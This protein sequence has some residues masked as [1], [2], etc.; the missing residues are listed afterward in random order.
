MPHKFLKTRSRERPGFI[1]AAWVCLAVLWLMPCLTLGQ[2]DP[3][4]PETATITSLG[5]GPP[6]TDVAPAGDAA[7]TIFTAIDDARKRSIVL[8]LIETLGIS[9][10]NRLEEGIESLILTDYEDYIVDSTTLTEDPIPLSSEVIVSVRVTLDSH[11]LLTYVGNIA[12]LAPPP[13]DAGGLSEDEMKSHAAL[14]E[15]MLLQADVATDVLL[16][17]IK[18]IESYTDAMALFKTA[19]DDRGVY[20]CLM[21]IGR[22]YVSLGG[23]SEAVESFDRAEEIARS[24]GDLRSEEAARLERARLLLLTGDYVGAS[25]EVSALLDDIRG[26]GYDDIEARALETAALSD[27]AAGNIERALDEAVQAIFLYEG[28]GD[29]KSHY[30]AYVS[31]GLML[32][33]IGEVEAAIETLKLA[34]IMSER[35]EDSERRAR[36]LTALGSAF[37]V[38][39]DYEGARL[40]LDEAVT[41]ARDAGWAYGEARALIERAKL[42]IETGNITRAAGDA[43]SAEELA[44]TLDV[45]VLLAVS[46]YVQGDILI[47]Q[48]DRVGALDSY[49]DAL[50]EARDIRAAGVREPYAPFTIDDMRTCAEALVSLA[51]EMND[52]K[53]A[54]EAISYYHGALTARHLF[55][56]TPGDFSLPVPDSVSVA[57]WKAVVGRTLGVDAV[58][59]SPATNILTERSLDALKEQRERALG[60]YEETASNIKR[61][62]PTLALLAGIDRPDYSSL[63]QLLGVGCAHVQYFIGPSRSFALIVTVNDLEIV[64]LPTGSAAVIEATEDF[65]AVMEGGA[66][67]APVMTPDETI[68]NTAAV[69]GA[70]PDSDGEEVPVEMPDVLT[71]DEAARRAAALLVSPLTPYLAGAETI[72]INT[73]PDL[74]GLSPA[75]L[76]G[77]SGLLPES[78]V[79]FYCPAIFRRYFAPDPALPTLTYLTILGR[80]LIELRAN[81]DLFYDAY[82]MDSLEGGLMMLPDETRSDGDFVLVLNEV[83]E[84]PAVTHPAA[85]TLFSDPPGNEPESMFCFLEL[86]FA[87]GPERGVI[88]LPGADPNAAGDFFQEM[89]LRVRE[90]G[91]PK[92]FEHALGSADGHGGAGSAQY[93]IF[94][95]Y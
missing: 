65:L 31:Y 55:T 62:T 21:G 26:A 82:F 8:F 89:I 76:T 88:I 11:A 37:F 4:V 16:D 92:G 36:V 19:R 57:E 28:L 50:A 71:A 91:A 46:L 35:M 10:Y 64:T 6:Q 43:A 20:T 42:S 87:A 14:A 13:E 27:F 66:A 68:D 81:E 51:A 85:L 95:D 38:T 63:R 32:L 17:P 73:G 44:R 12:R 72:G 48:G 80:G 53:S 34:K 7:P 54:A 83:P 56:R 22:A 59:K 78:T 94:G 79:V 49:L 25:G 40:Y 29:K 60:D 9:E 84:T 67:P 61:E 69:D 30:A 33:S 47:L 93:L 2:A 24:L 86:F 74:S 23:L 3:A 1:G 41:T 45:P 18:G 52:A 70:E 15:E 90:H 58:W 39:G 75:A 5:T 77:T